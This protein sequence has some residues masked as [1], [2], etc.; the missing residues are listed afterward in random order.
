MSQASN[1]QLCD[2]CQRILAGIIFVTNQGRFCALACKLEH[3]RKRE[4]PPPSMLF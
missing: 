3:D 2:Q 4:K 1:L